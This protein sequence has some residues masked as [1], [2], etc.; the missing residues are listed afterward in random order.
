MK[1][2]AGNDHIETLSFERASLTALG[3]LIVFVADAV[4]WPVRA[5]QQLLREDLAERS[6]R[7]GDDPEADTW[8]TPS[9]EQGHRTRPGPASVFAL[10]SKQLGAGGPRPGTRSV[11]TQSR[12]RALL[13]GSRCC[14]K[15]WPRGL[16]CWGAN[17]ER[18][19]APRAPPV[20]AALAQLG[21]ELDAALV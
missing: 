3:V 12:A 13:V 10:W 1:A 4:F 14:W 8:R 19:R 9:S 21:D 7:L 6:R 2:L 15:G 11:S 20:R 18:G 16:E 5:E 17:P